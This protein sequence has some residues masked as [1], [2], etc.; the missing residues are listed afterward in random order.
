[1]ISGTVINKDDFLI[2][3]S[4]QKDRIETGGEIFFNI[5]SWDNN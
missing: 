1:M 4:L 3:Q 2:G 5:I